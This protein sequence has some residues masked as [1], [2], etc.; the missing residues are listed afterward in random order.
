M[1]TAPFNKAERE[2]PLPIFPEPTPSSD[3]ALNESLSRPTPGAL[4]A[5]E[6]VTGDVAILGVGGKMGPTLARMVRRGLNQCGK[7]NR[8]IG[9]SRFSHS[10]VRDDL[11]AAG[12]ETVTCDLTERTA[13]EALPDASH[14]VFM[15]GQ[16]FGATESPEATWA[17]NVY[18]PA[19]AAQRYAG[20]QIVAFSSGSVYPNVPVS[21]GGSQESDPTEPLGDYANSVVGRE[22]LFTY[23]AKKN[24]TPMA[25]VRLNYAIDLRY[26]VLV[27]IARKTLMGEPIDLATGHVNVIWQGDAVAQSLQCFL[28][29]AV[30]PFV[31]NVTGPETISVRRLAHRFGVLLDRTPVLVGEEANTALLSNAG[32]ANGLFGYPGVPLERMI[33]WVAEWL[34]GNG[35][36]LNKPT[37]YETR[38]GRY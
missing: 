23:F 35:S 24:Q 20:S 25:L 31:I 10:A 14:V 30:P 34:K 12:I 27:D 5:L 3:A 9:V 22:R 29:A 1:Q 6:T 15:A 33:L 11:E 18:A 28:H 7:I 37:H 32:Q 21:S 8:V 36:L 4:K 13:V 2:R 38:N 26:G 19:L 16:K 17:M